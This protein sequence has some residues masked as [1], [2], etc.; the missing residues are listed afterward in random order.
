MQWIKRHKIL[1]S[2]LA[3]IL[4]L[5]GSVFGYVWSKLSLI[6]FDSGELPEDI[7]QAAETADTG[8]KTETDAETAPA[9]TEE[10]ETE[11]E[12]EI[13]LKAEDVPELSFVETEPVLPQA[14]AEPEKGKDEII[15]IMLLGTDERT[16]EGFSTDA[17]SDSMILASINVT[18]KKIKLVSLERAMGVPVLEG[19]YKGQYDW[20]THM[21]RFGGASLLLKTIRT[22]LSVD[23]DKYIRVNF[24]TLKAAVDAIGGVDVELTEAE[25]NYM[26]IGYMSHLIAE[27]LPDLVLGVNHLDGYLALG[28]ARLR[29]IDSDWTRVQRQRKLIIAGMAKIKAGG[30]SGLDTLANEVLPLVKTN[31]TKLE[32]AELLLL[33]PGLLGA[34]VEQMTIPVKDTYGLMKGMDDRTLYAVDF[35]TN[36]KILHDYLYEDED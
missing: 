6:Q 3:V 25:V 17:R 5:L 9:E 26:N 24:N 35:E 36:A 12:E 29:E 32:I 34:E 28:Y 14:P 15:N 23:V 30:L 20:L 13:I 10:T 19:E 7:P 2:V 18:D 8:D 33:A 31:L 21:F 16:K 22:C 4:L 11:E 1:I 27:D